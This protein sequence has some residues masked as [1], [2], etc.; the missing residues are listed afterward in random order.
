MITPIGKRIVEAVA[1]LDFSLGV[2]WPQVSVRFPT[3]VSWTGP[4][5]NVETARATFVWAT[6]EGNYSGGLTLPLSSGLLSLS[7]FSF[8]D[9]SLWDGDGG[10]FTFWHLQ[11]LW[12]STSKMQNNPQSRNSKE[13]LPARK[14][15]QPLLNFLLG[16]P[17]PGP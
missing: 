15:L 1:A 11:L 4:V 6:G 8:K 9:G 10:D 16:A 2:C 12:E 5:V 13:H 17:L 14:E 3:G 7:S